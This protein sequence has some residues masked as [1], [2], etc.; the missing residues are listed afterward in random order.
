MILADSAENSKN[1]LL[2]A[3]FAPACYNMD[4]LKL[5]MTQWL[6]FPCCSALP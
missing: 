2:I 1:Y 6:S 4:I 5:E 3:K